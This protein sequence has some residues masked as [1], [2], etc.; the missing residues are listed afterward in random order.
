MKKNKK[1]YLFSTATTE[2]PLCESNRREKPTN[3][4]REEKDGRMDGQTE[5]ES[6]RKTT[7][8]TLR[9]GE[10]KEETLGAW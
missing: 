9:H 8:S 5:K 2:A 10:G 4:E 1:G 3:H 6:E 7:A